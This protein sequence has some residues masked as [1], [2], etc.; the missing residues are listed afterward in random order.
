MPE[1]WRTSFWKVRDAIRPLYESNV[2]VFHAIVFSLNRDATALAPMLDTLEPAYR[3]ESLLQVIDSP[4]DGCATHQ[5]VFFARDRRGF[6]ALGRL[7]N[8]LDALLAAVPKGMLPVLNMPAVGSQVE[9][10]L[11]K[12]CSLLYHLAWEYEVNYLQAEMEHLDDLGCIGFFPWGECPQPS[13]CD[14]RRW[15]IHQ[16][17][18]CEQIQVFKRRF[19]AEGHHFPDMIDS[20]L[21]EGV[22]SSSL[23]AIDLLTYRAWEEFSSSQPPAIDKPKDRRATCTAKSKHTN[24]LLDVAA[25]KHEL[26]KHHFP[27]AGPCT[28]DPIG[29]KEL[30]KRLGWSQSRVSRRMAALFP[31]GGM[32]EYRECCRD[33]LGFGFLKRHSDGSVDLEATIE[34]DLLRDWDP[35]E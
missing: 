18:S 26:L 24:E 15:L 25:L 5:H 30:E 31:N 3:G 9:R 6:D 7:L 19:E 2:E 12:W 32:F 11:T 17:D 21:I 34:S 10:N 20:Y 29:Q 23:A 22:V 13:G 16:G 28:L 33:N 27:P 8:D 1:Q 14:P 4:T 35:N